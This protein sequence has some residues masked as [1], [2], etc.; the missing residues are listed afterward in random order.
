MVKKVLIFLLLT[1]SGFAGDPLHDKIEDLIG[2]D[3][4]ERNRSFIEIIFSPQE[5]YYRNK[6]VDVVKV[7][8]ALKENGLMNLFFKKPRT[9]EL[10]F[11]TNGK[12]LFFVKLM[13][14][15][16]RDMGYYRY[17]TKESTLEN[18]G[19]A[20]T[21]SL[22]AEYATDPTLLRRE[23]LKR[24]CDI[25][26]IE[27]LSD[28]KWNYKI[29]ISLAHMKLETFKDGDSVTYKRLN[30]EKWLNISE[31]KKLTLWSLKGNNWYPYIAFY[32]KSLRLLKVYKRDKKTWQIVLALPRDAAYVKIADLYSMKNIKDGLRVE[33]QGVK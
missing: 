6:S 29:D 21:I 3:T 25:V 19:F 24:G 18:S 2:Q 15:T 12:P 26:D 11:S 33:T 10:T 16:L 8:E 14:D 7:V 27:R 28:D 5:D 30:F 31:V 32:D 1:L 20:W 22:T 17:I 13:G 4:Y 9:L 23:L